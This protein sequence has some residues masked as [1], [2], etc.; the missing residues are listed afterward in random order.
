MNDLPGSHYDSLI[1]TILIPLI[2]VVAG[3]EIALCDE[4]ICRRKSSTRFYPRNCMALHL[5]LLQPRTRA[6][7]AGSQSRLQW[8]ETA[9][10]RYKNYLTPQEGGGPIAWET[11]EKRRGGSSKLEK[12]IL[13]HKKGLCQQR[14]K[15]AWDS[16]C[17]APKATPHWDIS[18]A[19]GHLWITE[20]VASL[21]CLLKQYHKVARIMF[22]MIICL[23]HLMAVRL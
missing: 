16:F 10:E 6:A 9:K 17:T 22:I 4:F 19:I 2:R 1:C 23:N 14:P 15:I 8:I 11:C 13:M 12:I 21:C 20:Q 7:T 5:K 3:C 18:F